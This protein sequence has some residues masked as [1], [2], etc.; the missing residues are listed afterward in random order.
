MHI[1]LFIAKAV[2]PLKLAKKKTGIW[3]GH[4][5]NQQELILRIAECSDFLFWVK[6]N[7]HV[8]DNI[9]L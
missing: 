8:P 6:V 4:L 2:F 5:R 7:E 9:S 3:L 1:V